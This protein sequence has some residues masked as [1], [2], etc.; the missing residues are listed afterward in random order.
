MSHAAWIGQTAVAATST[1]P[2]VIRM[3]EFTANPGEWLRQA[4]ERELVLIRHGRPVALLRPAERRKSADTDVT[5]VT[6]FARNTRRV[7]D[8]V[9]SSGAAQT[10]A[11]YG[12]PSVV[13]EPL[14]VA[15]FEGLVLAN[16]LDKLVAERGNTVPID[17]VLSDLDLD[18]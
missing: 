4:S 3:S 5:D 1:R 17:E 14:N 6:Y 2:R 7:L 16:A 9:T 15:N 8:E 10:L 13:V 18:E 12:K 11:R